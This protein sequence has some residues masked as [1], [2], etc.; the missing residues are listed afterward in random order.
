GH[1]PQAQEP[2]L[3]SG[4][5]MD[6]DGR[7]PRR[8]RGARAGRRPSQAAAAAALEGTPRQAVMQAE[9]PAGAPSK[10]PFGRGGPDGPPLGDA[11]STSLPTTD[12]EIQ[13]KYL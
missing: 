7:R 12:D 9:G 11:R 6:P 2:R 4:S 5:Q 10:K 3:R 8:V 1:R 13:E